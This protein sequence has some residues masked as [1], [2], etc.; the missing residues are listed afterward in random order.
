MNE[1]L[2]EPQ[3]MR[4]Q[5]DE[6]TLSEGCHRYPAEGMCAMEAVSF[7][8]GEPF[9]EY[10]DCACPVV[11]TFVIGFNDSLPDNASRDKWIKP[12]IPFIVGSRALLS[13]GRDD[14][15]TIAK[16]VLAAG[17]AAVKHLS[18]LEADLAAPTTV[19]RPL[20]LDKLQGNTI[21]EKLKNKARASLAN[22]TSVILTNDQT[23][24]DYSSFISSVEYS[25]IIALEAFGVLASFD[26]RTEQSIL[27]DKINA[28]RVAIMLEILAVQKE[29]L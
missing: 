19:P 22:L 8:S 23:S 15:S 28:A 24:Q 26:D 4:E 20:V 29:V 3:S 5:Y 2:S 21:L 6:I 27:A 10:P 18:A 7:I 25:T 12:L 17:E 16:R 11:T 1:Q 13:D 9:S 14:S